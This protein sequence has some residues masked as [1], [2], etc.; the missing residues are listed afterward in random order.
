[1]AVVSST[2][3]WVAYCGKQTPPAAA[4]PACTCGRYM[5]ESWPCLSAAGDSRAVIGSGA[6]LVETSDQ[7]ASRDDE[8]VSTS[9]GS[10]SSSCAPTTTSRAAANS[11]QQ[12]LMHE[13]GKQLLSVLLSSGKWPAWVHAC[14]RPVPRHDR[15]VHA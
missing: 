5:I 1:V 6:R 8:R 11:S 14:S 9:R 2:R 7:K 13:L 10:S 15:S 4:P 3:I 12:Q